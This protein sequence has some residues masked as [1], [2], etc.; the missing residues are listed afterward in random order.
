MIFAYWLF[1]GATFALA[2]LSNATDAEEDRC[3]SPEPVTV[4]ETEII[5]SYGTVTVFESYYNSFSESPEDDYTTIITDED[6]TSVYDDGTATQM[7]TSDIEYSIYPTY[8]TSCSS[9]W[10]GW[11]STVCVTFTTWLTTTKTATRTVTE[12]KPTTKT[13]TK[14]IFETIT[15][16][17]TKVVTK[18]ATKT[19]DHYTTKTKTV[20]HYTTDTVTDTTTTTDT[21]TEIS[22][23]TETDISI[24][25][26]TDTVTTTETDISITTETDISVTTEID[27]TTA[28]NTTTTTDIVTTTYTTELPTTIISEVIIT[29]TV[30]TTIIINTTSTTT[31]YISTT[32]TTTVE[33]PTNVTQTVT[34]TSTAT[35]TTTAISISPTTDTATSTTTLVTTSLVTFTTI[36]TFITVSEI[37]ITDS[38]TST[39]TFTTTQAIT[40][41]SPTTITLP[42]VTIV[43]TSYITAA[44]ECPRPT[45]PPG[46]NI[47]A[48]DPRSNRTWGCLPGTVCNRPKPADCNVYADLPDETY[49]CDSDSL[50][51]ESPPYLLTMWRDNVTSYYPP[52]EGYFNLAPEAFG[53]SDDIFA[54]HYVTTTE[55]GYPTTIATGNWGS[56]PDETA[57]PPSTTTGA[58]SVTSTPDSRIRRRLA[59]LWKR[60]PVAPAICYDTCN[61]ASLEAQSVGKSQAL[62]QRDS[63]FYGYYDGCQ[64]CIAANTDDVQLTTRDYLTPA[65]SQWIGFCDAN[66]P[67]PVSSGGQSQVSSTTG[68]TTIP[69]APPSTET[70]VSI[71]ST[72]STSSTSSE[73]S[74]TSSTTSTQSSTSESTPP[75]TTPPPTT[76]PLT[77]ATPTGNFTTPAT[78]PTAG[79]PAILRESAL[80]S[81]RSLFTFLS[82]FFFL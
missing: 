20:D 22:I 46:A 38:V 82:M 8:S 15:E 2:S 36:S 81:P 32:Y 45:N 35:S 17:T 6:T 5:T 23:T 77:T 58:A 49:I 71:P 74:T 60:G 69:G 3:Y 41:V 50:C 62:C 26:E 44:V 28:T 9:Q 14:I 53:L 12:T 7:I 39:T 68:G 10:Y 64:Q 66:Y 76:P 65:F 34:E 61:A 52:T 54:V 37:S 80:L 79:A 43:T 73:S 56:Q 11:Q 63:A 67:I 1:A 78:I 75:P 70:S 33:I 25:T 21:E 24:T 57:Y 42:P 30:P 59:A 29:T 13:V 51:V 18:T 16:S 27:I 47:P 48:Y 31:D 72:S 55:N 40:T 19:V 4:T